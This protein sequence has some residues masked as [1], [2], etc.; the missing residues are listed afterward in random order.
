MASVSHPAGRFPLPVPLLSLISLGL[1]V[2][3]F[4][5]AG[6]IQAALHDR[7]NRDTAVA[8]EAYLAVVTPARIGPYDPARLVSGV[9]ALASA[10]FWRGGLQVAVGRAAILPDTVGLIPQVESLSALPAEVTLPSGERA[11]MVSFRTRDRTT[12]IGWVA[13]WR[14]LQPAPPDPLAIIPA[15]LVGVAAVGLILAA[16]LHWSRRVFRGLVILGALAGGCAALRLGVDV[17]QSATRATDQR[18]SF[19]RHLLEIAA[20]ADGVRQREL[21]SL[22]PELAPLVLRPPAERTDSVIRRIEDGS[23]IATIIAAVPDGRPIELRMLPYESKLT[24]FFATLMGCAALLALTLSAAAW[25]G[26]PQR[27]G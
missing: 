17:S 24:T 7:A 12:T 14:M 18:L 8:I 19:A 3:M 6:R 27:H 2:G 21:I 22:T 23:L 10:S 20:T 11:S 13:V 9:S 1:L 16:W 15:A 5:L 26:Q 4:L 25:A